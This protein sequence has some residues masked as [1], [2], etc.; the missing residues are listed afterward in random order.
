[1]NSVNDRPNGPGFLHAAAGL[2]SLSA[3]RITRLGF[4]PWR[5]HPNIPLLIRQQD[6][7]HRLGMDWLDNCIRPRREK[8]I[9]V[10]RPGTGLDFVPRSPLNSVQM[11]AK[12]VSAPEPNPETKKKDVVWF[13]INADRPHIRRNCR[14][15]P[16]NGFP[17]SANRASAAMTCCGCS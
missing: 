9:D 15:A 13:A 1:M 8:A 2:S 4:I 7:R 14:M 11:P 6:D 3:P 5:P 12:Q 10:V 16:D 17:A